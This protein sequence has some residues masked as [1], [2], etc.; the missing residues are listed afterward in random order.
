MI[1]NETYHKCHLSSQNFQT[2]VKTRVASSE[3]TLTMIA[4]PTNFYF[5]DLPYIPKIVFSGVNDIILEACMQYENH[6][7]KTVGE[8]T[9]YSYYVLSHYFKNR[10]IVKKAQIR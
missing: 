8:E 1:Y 7:I 5:S 4:S 10:P 3:S 9:F 6:P 2:F